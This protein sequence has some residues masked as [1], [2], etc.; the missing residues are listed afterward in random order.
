MILWNFLYRKLV[1]VEAIGFSPELEPDYLKDRSTNAWLEKV[2]NLL[3]TIDFESDNMWAYM[4][5]RPSGRCIIQ[6]PTERY[7][8]PCDFLWAPRIDLSEIEITGLWFCAE[9]HGRGYWKGKEVDIQLASDNLSLRVIER[10]TRGLKAVWGMNISY[11]VVAHLFIGDLLC[12]ILTESSSSSR[13]VRVTDRTIVFTALA[14]LERSFMLHGYLLDPWHIAIDGNG[15]F[16]LLDLHA[17]RYHAPHQQKLL[18]KD[19]QTEHWG[20][21]RKLFD[22]IAM[23]PPDSQVPPQ[24]KKVASTVLART[25]SPLRLLAIPVRFEVGLRVHLAEDEN[26]NRQ[27]AYDVSSSHKRKEGCITAEVP[28]RNKQRYIRRMSGIAR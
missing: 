26:V 5:D 17:L 23:C 2:Q 25:P 7:R 9:G 13:P 10:E 19:A 20:N 3:D 1:V 18:E 4:I 15:Q 21:I 24:F 22:W 12:G 16:R 27:L 11:E 8:I 28:S 6:R 14:K